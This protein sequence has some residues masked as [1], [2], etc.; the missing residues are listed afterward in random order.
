MK[1]HVVMG[2]LLLSAMPVLAAPQ[3][4][5]GSLVFGAYPAGVFEAGQEKVEGAAGNATFIHAM[6][7]GSATRQTAE[8]VL[9]LPG[10]A[11]H[12][13]RLRFTT[14]LKLE[15]VDRATCAMELRGKDDKAL[16]I[17]EGELRGGTS[18]WRDCAVV[19][20]VPDNVASVR[21]R[22]YMLGNGK[23]WSD[24]FNIEEVSAD[25]PATPRLNSNLQRNT[26][27]R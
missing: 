14:R 17:S 4:V 21:L 13:K 1:S 3:P 16:A 23:V 26:D 25:V 11:Y 12:G 27:G 5:G 8:L 20:Q 10:E 6:K 9:P 24:G 18:D 22:F 7:D 15:A 2:V 19:M